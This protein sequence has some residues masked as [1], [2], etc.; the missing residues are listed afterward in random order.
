MKLQFLVCLALAIG[1]SA[2]HAQG[3]EPAGQNCRLLAPPTDA[4]ESPDHGIVLRI[5]PR[6]SEISPSYSGC[7]TMWAPQ[8]NAWIRI[9]ETEIINGDPV[10]LWTP[11]GISDATASCRY[12][13]GKTISGDARSCPAPEFLIQ[14]SFPAG[15]ASKLFAAKGGQ[16]S[17]C[18]MR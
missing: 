7:Q 3:T 15:C 13:K 10:R 12:A 9:S 14:Q 2:S 18:E 8:A 11:A 16:V 1:V 17:G 6:A 5:Y 4:G